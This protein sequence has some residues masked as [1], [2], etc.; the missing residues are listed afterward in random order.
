MNLFEYFVRSHIP[1]PLKVN[2]VPENP[3]SRNPIPFVEE[4]LVEAVRKCASEDNVGLLLSGGMDSS[5]VYSIA[6]RNKIP[7]KTYVG[8]CHDKKTDDS[9]W[10]T[11]LEPKTVVVKPTLQKILATARFMSEVCA[12]APIYTNNDMLLYCLAVEAKHDGIDTLILCDGGDELFWGYT[13]YPR[14]TFDK[15]KLSEQGHSVVDRIYYG[16]NIHNKFFLD[17]LFGYKNFPASPCYKW[18]TEHR[19][20]PIYRLI[21][22]FDQVWMLP[23]F[24]ARAERITKLTGIKFVYP[25]LDTE[26][27]NL[28]NTLPLKWRYKH[29]ELRYIQRNIARNYLPTWLM[30]RPKQGFASDITNWIYSGECYNQMQKMEFPELNQKLVQKIIKRHFGKTWNPIHNIAVKL[31]RR[32]IADYFMV[33]KLYY[34]GLWRR[35]HP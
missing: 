13:R 7:L 18:L 14:I 23:Q 35:Y 17:S 31:G 2:L 21:S 3:S 22:F 26:L 11:R 9:V 20:M 28:V 32:K 19:T 8:G 16:F 10:A 15:E 4:L 34:Y 12:D 1:T 5:L 30:L 6:Q 29:S 27:V 24:I 25:Y 33:N